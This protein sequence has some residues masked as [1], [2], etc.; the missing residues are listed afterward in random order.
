MPCQDAGWP[1]STSQHVSRSGGGG[2]SPPKTRAPLFSPAPRA[3]PVVAAPSSGGGCATGGAARAR[4]DRSRE[5]RHETRTSRQQ[6]H[7]SLS[8][9]QAELSHQTPPRGGGTWSAFLTSPLAAATGGGAGSGSGAGAGAGLPAR[10]LLRL[11]MQPRLACY[12]QVRSRLQR[13]AGDAGLR[14]SFRRTR[15]LLQPSC[16]KRA[17]SIA[18]RPRCPT[19][20]TPPFP[21]LSYARVCDFAG[22]GVSVSEGAAAAAPAAT[23]TAAASGRPRRP[24]HDRGLVRIGRRAASRRRAG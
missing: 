3:G 12:A 14:R 5:R 18:L 4:G 16:A 8:R 15:T 23:D 20:R 11:R 10:S 24:R 1:C 7:A 17:P 6:P 13:T 2:G 21:P 19:S 22:W 9:R